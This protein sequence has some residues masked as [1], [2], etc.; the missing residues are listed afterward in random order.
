MDAEL[1]K[2]LKQCIIGVDGAEDKATINKTVDSMLARDSLALRTHLKNNTPDIDTTF[3]F[4][5]NHCDEDHEKMAMPIGI[6]FF[7]PGV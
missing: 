2:R 1:T 3:T 4:T 6:G 5:C 7:W